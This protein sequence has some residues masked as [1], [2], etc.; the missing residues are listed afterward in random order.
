ME[1]TKENNHHQLQA[2][3]AEKSIELERLKIQL[4]SLQ[5]TEMEQNEII[6]KLTHVE[7]CYYLYFV[8]EH[9]F[10]RKQPQFFFARCFNSR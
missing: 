1:K 3:I 8:Y 6:N 10:R 9:I 4:N 7:Y 5:R 2:L